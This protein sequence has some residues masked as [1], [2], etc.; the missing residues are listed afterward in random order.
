MSPNIIEIARK[1]FG[2]PARKR[3][4]PRTGMLL[5][6]PEQVRLTFE[7][8]RRLTRAGKPKASEIG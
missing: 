6:T 7:L 8:S 2:R 1:A 4:N 3:V 5:F